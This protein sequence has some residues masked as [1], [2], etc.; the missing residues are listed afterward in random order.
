L[1]VFLKQAKKLLPYIDI[2]EANRV[3]ARAMKTKGKKGQTSPLD[4]GLAYKIRQVFSTGKNPVLA[5][6]PN[7][8]H[9][10]RR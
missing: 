5:L 3:M 6:F 2:G 4:K 8:V 9:D 7:F 10:N 1:E